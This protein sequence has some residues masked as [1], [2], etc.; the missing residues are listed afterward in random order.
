VQLNCV[1]SGWPSQFEVALIGQCMQNSRISST[2]LVGLHPANPYQMILLDMKGHPPDHMIHMHTEPLQGYLDPI[3]YHHH[4]GPEDIQML[5]DRV[6]GQLSLISTYIIV[7]V[8]SNLS[9][10]IQIWNRDS[11]RK[12]YPS[13]ENIDSKLPIDGENG[14]LLFEGIF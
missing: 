14:K 13:S 10:D 1:P 11:K 2:D 9:K 3:S 6:A 5:H 4:V 7:P 8:T 12:Y